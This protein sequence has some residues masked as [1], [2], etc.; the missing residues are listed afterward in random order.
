MAAAIVVAAG[1]S[2]SP[3]RVSAPKPHPFSG[4]LASTCVIANP[5]AR[6][7]VGGPVNGAASNGRFTRPVSLDEGA[8]TIAVAP[9]NAHPAISAQLAEC[10]LRAGLTAEGFP[11]EQEAQL[12]GLTFGL[13]TVTVEDDLLS[14]HTLTSG[15]GS[16]TPTPPARHAY[17]RRLAWVAVVRPEI[18][19]S[20]PTRSTSTVPPTAPASPPTRPALP[21]YQVL[22]VDANTG[23]DGFVYV[24]SRNANCIDA[25]EPPALSPAVENVSLPW[26]LVHRGAAG[27]SAAINIAVRACDGGGDAN[28]SFL[29]DRDRPGLVTTDV[30]RPLNAC[31]AANVRQFV[32]DAAT[33]GSTLPATLIHGPVGAV[34]TSG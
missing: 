12:T 25:V 8:L 13:A 2:S 1:C 31:G 32:L 14:G 18:K 5:P 34:D 28:S 33:V 21:G 29:A 19:S 7:Q 16:G 24:A 15:T 11:I 20:C 9:A 30:L 4:V 6:P 17:H 10:N 3:T 27:Y 26:T 23:A 22:V